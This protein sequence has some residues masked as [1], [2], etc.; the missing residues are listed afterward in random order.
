MTTDYQERPLEEELPLDE[1][2]R[3]DE[4]GNAY[5][6]ECRYELPY[7]CAHCIA[8]G[9]VG[10]LLEAEIGKGPMPR[11]ASTSPTGSG[12]HTWDS[13]A[14]FVKEVSEARICAGVHFRNSTV[15]GQAM[16]RKVAE[17]ALQRFGKEVAAK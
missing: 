12:E 4:P 17:L 15:V 1:G 11:L 7:P 14:A 13:P 3:D 10:A 9:A 16:G 8:S 2:E 5:C 6:A